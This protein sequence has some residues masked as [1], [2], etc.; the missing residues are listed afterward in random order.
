M[1][2]Q[3]VIR[4]ILRYLKPYRPTLLA[5]FAAALCSVPLGLL[6]PVLIGRAVDAAVGPG[7]VDFSTIIQS[8]GLLLTT[9]CASALFSWGMQWLARK[10]SAQAAQDMRRDAYDR[11]NVVPLSRLDTHKHGDLVNRL[12]VDADIV[13]EGLLQALAQLLPGI[14]TILA[15]IVVMCILNLWIALV[16]ILVTPL[17]ILFARFVGVRT[18]AFFHKQSNDQGR[19]SSYIN[20]MVGNQPLVQALGFEEKAAEEF[21]GLASSYY[22]SNFKATFYSSIINP[23]TRFVNAIVYA[24]VAVFGA[25]YAIAGG[26][27]VGGLSAFLTYANQYTKPFNE[28]TAVLTQM[29]S[30]IASA[31]RM[32]EI[33]GWEAERS[34]PEGAV[35]LTAVEGHVAAERVCFSY[36]KDRPLIRDFTMDAKPGQR[37]ALVGPTGCGKTTLINLLMRFYEID[38]GEISVDGVPIDYIQKDSLRGCYGMVLQDTWLKQASVRENIAYARPA[39]SMAE[40][41]EA[42]KTALAHN[43]IMRLPEG[44]DTV[45]EEGGSNLSAGQRQL[46]C[47]ARIVLAKPDMLIL[48]EA[49]SSIDTRTEIAIGRAMDALMAGHTSFVVAHRLSTIQNAD[50]ILVMEDGRIVERG[51]HDALLEKGGF[52][53]R[54]FKSQ[55]QQIS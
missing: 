25:L 7:D 27:T 49:T 20:E 35:R 3:Q 24:A 21:A 32:L 45:L 13:S 6:A 17:S 8:L 46:L 14:V 19:L 26:I 4:H 15:T 53:A 36:V 38:S 23:G 47:I 11:L 42:A 55:F 31:R 54:L 12:V 50:Q 10:V 44:Y 48:D 2:T 33:T 16:V 34:D 28:V 43:F 22:E 52:Y 30:A 18:S 41:V 51:T 9:V 37:I 29:Q 1:N 5:A 39:A 40:V